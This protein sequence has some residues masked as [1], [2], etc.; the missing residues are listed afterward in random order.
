MTY[1]Q[2]NKFCRSLHATTYVCQWGGAH[3]WKIGGKVFAIGGWTSHGKLGVTF[4]TS[5]LNYEILREQPGC[6]PAP[7]LASRGMKWIQHY[8]EPGLSDADLKYYIRESYR[9]VSLKLPKKK[10]QELGVNQA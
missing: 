9:L 5:D 7:Y 3:V 6:R 4:K 2:Y 10:Q 1:Q 8:D